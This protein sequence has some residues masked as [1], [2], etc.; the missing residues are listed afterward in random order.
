MGN[1]IY[2]IV[3]GEYSDW[4]VVGYC[5]SYNRAKRYVANANSKKVYGGDDCY[6]LR[7]ENVDDMRRAS[8]VYRDLTYCAVNKGGSWGLSIWDWCAKYVLGDS[9]CTVSDKRASEGKIFVNVR[10]LR[11]GRWKYPD[12]ELAEEER[13]DK[14]A[15][16]RLYQYLYEHDVEELP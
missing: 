7:V 12:N 9:G 4:I 11:D 5:K 1:P 13:A 8:G 10:V 6:I 15:Q 3:S 16:D 14:I 2:L